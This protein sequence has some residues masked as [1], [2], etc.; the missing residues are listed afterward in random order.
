MGRALQIPFGSSRDGERM[1]SRTAGL[2]LGVS[3]AAAF[4]SA[5]CCAQ[6]A[7]T[8]SPQVGG[9]GGIA[10]GVAAAPIFDAQGRSITAGGFVGA[11]PV[12][13]EDV[14]KQAG[15]SGWRHKMGVPEKNVIVETNGSGVCLID[16]DN[17]GWL[18]IYLVN[19]STFDALDGKEEPPHAALFHNNHDGTFTDVSAQAGVTNDRWG[20]GCSVAD[21]D[22]WPDLFVGNYGKNRLYHNNHDGTFTDV[23]EKAGVQ[24]GNWSSGSAWGDYDGDGFLDLYVSGYVHLDRGNLP[25]GDSKSMNIAYCQYRGVGV[26]CGPRG[27]PGEPDHLFHNNGNGTFTDV[28]AKAGVEDRYRYFGFTSIF[29]SLN[30]NGKP[31]LVVGNDSEPNYLYID[32]GD[33][34]FSD[35]SYISG[36]GLNAEGREIASMGIAAGDYENNGR[37][38]FFITDFGDDYKVLYHND[39]DANFTDVSYK[40]GVAQ[41]TIPFV[42]WG[43]GFIDYDND[44]WLDL[45]MVNGHVYPQVDQHGWG[46]TFA[47][48]PLLFHNVPDS[49]GKGRKFDYVPPVKGTGLAIVV[50]ARGA[51]FGDLFN[52]GKIDV[53]INPIDGP[54]VLLRNVN[55]DHHHWVEAK[56]VGGPKSPRD[57]TC[58]TAYLTANG[59]RQRQD[60]LA[61]GSYISSNDRR[62]HFGLGDATDP[63]SLEIHWPSGK[64]ETVKLPTL[65]RIYTIAEG[66]GITGELC[67]GK[68]CTENRVAHK[69]MPQGQP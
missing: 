21:Y 10:S 4:L 68:S 52:D 16:Y 51:A 19:G 42:G 37:I 62:L 3:F 66:V 57:A 58:A 67:G 26:N 40:A 44:G 36:F 30:G 64:K 49:A 15:L 25:I 9:M 63:G 6:Q 39:G 18:D 35:Q 65:D 53:V 8:N 61:S 55:P 45:F 60:V 34:T 50:P 46:T 14:T 12:V 54:P 27:L 22:G 2:I 69:A 7:Q 29:I 32:K 20:Y 17:D 23:A 11:G 1:S 48:R 43:D 13:F 59:M 5:V 24:L 33:G 31:D 56:L 28:T 38:D 47:E 41:T